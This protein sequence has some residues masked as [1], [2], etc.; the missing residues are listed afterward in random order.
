MQLTLRIALIILTLIYL[1]YIFKSIKNKKI[2]ISF[3]IFWVFTA[4]ILIIAIAI[5]NLIQN[6]S[7]FL[8]FTLT[9]NMI[10]CVTIFIAFYLIFNLTTILSKENKKNVNLIQEISI[11]KKRVEDLE[12]KQEE[13]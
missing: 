1:F 10:F 5:P 9:T 3:S 8:G 6:I 13:K 4:F 12:K 2:Q 11:L 7:N